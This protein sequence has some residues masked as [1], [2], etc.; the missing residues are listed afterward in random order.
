MRSSASSTCVATPR[1]QRAPAAALDRAPVTRPGRAHPPQADSPSPGTQVRRRVRDNEGARHAAPARLLD[2]LAGPRTHGVSGRPR[3]P[4]SARNGRP[5]RGI[6]ASGRNRRR[7]VVRPQA[8]VRHMSK[9]SAHAD[10]RTGHTAAAT[11]CVALLSRDSA[12]RG[13]PVAAS[14][15]SSTSWPFTPSKAVL[16]RT[17]MVVAETGS[18]KN[19]WP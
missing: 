10:V 16:V 2:G 18:T 19:A 15:T 1:G 5:T 9:V 17:T 13:Q 4:L 12:R 7:V 6:A 14:T 8:A 11:S 3:P